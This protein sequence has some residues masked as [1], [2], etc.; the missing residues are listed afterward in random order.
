MNKSNT[1]LLKTTVEWKNIPWHKIER[2]VFKLLSSHIQSRTAW[3]PSCSSQA[4]EN[5]DEVLVGKGIS[6]SQGNSG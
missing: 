5:L 1:E 4:S 2:A 3:R 6:R